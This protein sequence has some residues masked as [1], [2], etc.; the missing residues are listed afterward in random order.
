MSSNLEKIFDKIG[1]RVNFVTHPVQRAFRNEANQSAPVRLNIVTVDGEEAF[2]I[3]VRSDLESSLDL[4]VLEVR[5]KDRHLVLLA[6][7]VDADGRALV[8]DH[9]LCGHD[10]RHLFVAAV[11]PV[12]TVAAAKASL[13]PNAVRDQETGLNTKKRNRRRNKVFVRQGEWFFIP[14]E[15]TPDVKFIRRS[16][17]LV[18]GRGSKP[19]TAQY[20]YREGGQTVRVCREYPNGLTMDEYKSL[21]ETS[22][23]AQYFNWRDMQRDANVYVKGRISHADHATVVLDTWHRVLMNSERRTETVAFL[24]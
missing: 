23:R 21:I 18:R 12:S 7:Q 10:E 6:R 4:N 16:E 17:P 8:K 22:P 9:F 14:V 19:H 5:A 20:A 15:I 11:S 13:K 1:A 3:S 24:D 2:E